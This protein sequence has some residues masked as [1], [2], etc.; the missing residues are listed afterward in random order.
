ME[1]QES[2]H[3]IEALKR[4]RAVTY[5]T[6]VFPFACMFMILV[7]MFFYRYGSESVSTYMDLF[8]YTSPMICLFMLFLSLALKMCIWHK[9]Q[10]LLPIPLIAVNVFDDY[11]YE[12]VIDE[13][14]VTNAILIA[15][16]VLSLFNGY[17]IF[18]CK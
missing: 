7:S 1:N 13:L 3:V 18:C 9:I 14:I 10:C 5:V 8:F 15:V 17:R 6:K 11:I 12:L 2:R 16:V 4:L